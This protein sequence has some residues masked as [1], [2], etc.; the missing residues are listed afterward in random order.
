MAYAFVAR[1]LV[2]LAWWGRVRVSG[3][4]LVPATGPALVVPNHDSQMDP[5]VLGIAL[6]RR[7]RLRFLARANLWRIPGLGPVLSAMSQIPIERGSGDVAA[8]DSAVAA[9]RDGEAVCIFPEGRLSRGRRLRA[10]SGVARLHA[11]HPEATVVLCAIQGTTDYARFPRRPRVLIEFFAPD[12]A[13][14]SAGAL[15]AAI[16]ER[17]PPVSAGRHPRPVDP[18]EDVARGADYAD[19]A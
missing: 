12:P 8:L 6:R 18:A 4:D 1:L 14:D 19:R 11:A 16:R 3:E 5:V 9:L 10:H 2:P 15:L 7:R 13:A 17:V